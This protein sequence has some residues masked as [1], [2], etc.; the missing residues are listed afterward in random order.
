MSESNIPGLDGSESNGEVDDPLYNSDSNS[1]SE[2]PSNYSST[3]TGDLDITLTSLPN[4]NNSD[5]NDSTLVNNIFDNIRAENMAAKTR[6]QWDLGKNE[7]INSFESWKGHLLYLLNTDKNFAP[8]LISG[9]SWE[10]KGRNNPLRGLANEQEVVNLELMLGQIANFCSVISR[11]T[12]LRNSTSLDH[13]WQ[14][15]RAHY[16]FQTSGSNFLNLCDLRLEND[17]RPE[18]L[19]QRIQ[20][21][22]EF[23]LLTTTCGI[24]H[25]GDKIMED[26]EMSPTLENIVVFLWLQ[27]LHK[28]L[29]GLVKMKYGPDL[30]SKTLASIKPEIS[31]ALDSLLEELGSQPTPILRAA[32]TTPRIYPRNLQIRPTASTSSS[33]FNRYKPSIAL[34]YP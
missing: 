22:F 29:P 33:Q 17:E 2:G 25:H 31:A 8:F 5:S 16:G 3:A 4:H 11:N 23:N 13:V 18:D 15:I 28:D 24:S 30:R 19:F 20:S 26:E 27:L 14:H 10:K 6:K 34:Q 21:F 12:I 1:P 32:G 7:T 9:K